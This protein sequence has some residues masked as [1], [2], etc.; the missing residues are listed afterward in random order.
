MHAYAPP[1]PLPSELLIMLLCVR[2]QVQEQKQR[3]Q[4]LIEG[5]IADK[6]RNA[7]EL[8]GDELYEYVF[9]VWRRPSFNIALF[10][11]VRFHRQVYEL[12]KAHIMDPSAT[13]SGAK[14]LLSGVGAK[15]IRVRWGP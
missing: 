12:C 8:L 1:R 3:Q 10:L 6:R 5:F 11:N 7:V 14:E 4:G 15:P 9:L 2:R 13:P